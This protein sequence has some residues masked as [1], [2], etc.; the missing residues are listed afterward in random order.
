MGLKREEFFA[1]C[2]KY[3]RRTIFIDEINDV[4]ES[5]QTY[6]RHLKLCYMR[7]RSRGLSMWSCTQAPVSVPSFTLGQCRHKY[8]FALGHPNQRKAAELFYEAPIP[9]DLMPEGSYKF[10]YRGPGNITMG[11]VVLDV[12]VAA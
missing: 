3:G 1:W 5:A 4:A 9:W 7:G 10:V 2:L 8:I 12:P 6:P 11:P